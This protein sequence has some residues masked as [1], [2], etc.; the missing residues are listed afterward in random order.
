MPGWAENTFAALRVRDF[1]VLWFGTWLSFVAFFMSTAVQSIVAFELTGFNTSVGS[2]IFAQGLA[3][4]TLAPLGGALA[5]RLPKRRVVATGQM[6]TAVIYLTISWLIATGQLRVSFLALGALGMGAAFSFLGPA[7]QALVVDVVPDDCRGNAIVLSGVANTGSRVMGPALAGALLPWALVGAS[8]AYLVMA[9]CYALSASLLLLL[10]KSRVREGASDAHVLADVAAGL[11]YLFGTRLS[12]L[13]VPFVLVIMLGYP[14][15]TLLPG[16]LENEL[17]HPTVDVSALLSVSAA[18]AL[19]ASLTVAG[20]TDA[21]VAPR[22]FRIMGLLFGLLLFAFSMVPS[23]RMALVV[24]FFLGAAS[25]GFQALGT[26][27]LVREAEPAMVGRVMS[28]TM[29][30]F[31]GFGMVALPIGVLADALGERATLA[32]MATVV[33][34]LIG[35]LFLTLRRDRSARE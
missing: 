15:V 16:L 20:L 9:G 35:A 7:R 13:A 6:F 33:C 10:P 19:S 8:G 29:L 1:R 32:I 31:A 14:Y 18:G 23:Y 11:R 3:M 22:L 30:A 4:M 25:G 21:P 24:M 17:G 12:R 28:S 27:L 34:S 2:V 26:A 5:D